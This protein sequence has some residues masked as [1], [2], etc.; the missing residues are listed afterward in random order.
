MIFYSYFQKNVFATVLIFFSLPR[1]FSAVLETNNGRCEIRTRR[2]DFLCASCSVICSQVS[3][4]EKIHKLQCLRACVHACA[5]A[6]IVLLICMYTRTYAYST[7]RQATQTHLRTHKK[8]IKNGY[9]F[10]LCFFFFSH[11]AYFRSLFSSHMRESITCVLSVPAPDFI[12]L[13][14]FKLFLQYLYSD[15]LHF[16]EEEFGTNASTASP[17]SLSKRERHATAHAVSNE[18][19]ADLPG[20]WALLVALL[21]TADFYGVP[22]LQDVIEQELLKHVHTLDIARKYTILSM[23]MEEAS[24]LLTDD[25]RKQ[26]EV[27]LPPL[28]DQPAGAETAKK[29]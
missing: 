22:S 15:T 7:C 18:E 20:A 16:F 1:R 24:G 9:V 11:S 25:V 4:E 27:M 17:S 5:H 10:N 21:R 19:E 12:P 8:N 28:A 3:K 13:E 29:L 23:V 6:G 26:L 2:S 14:A